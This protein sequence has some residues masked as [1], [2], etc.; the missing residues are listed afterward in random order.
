MIYAEF[1]Y[2]NVMVTVGIKNLDVDSTMLKYM[3]QVKWHRNWSYTT[4][5][6]QPML[7]FIKRLIDNMIT[8]HT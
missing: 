3:I 8:A 6:V 5:I 4:K 2:Q 1:I 7:G